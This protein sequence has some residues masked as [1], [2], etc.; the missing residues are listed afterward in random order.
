MRD[1]GAPVES[2]AGNPSRGLPLFDADFLKATWYDPSTAGVSA[3]RQDKATTIAAA[4]L[5][6]GA[7]LL[8]FVPLGGALLLVTGSLGLAVSVEASMD[9]PNPQNDLAS[10]DSMT[11]PA[12]TT[13]ATGMAS[14]VRQDAT[15]GCGPS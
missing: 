11:A 6:L 12:V 8:F 5:V 9:G 1:Q 15:S 7:V 10:D 3:P 14:I 2:T 13:T 4:M